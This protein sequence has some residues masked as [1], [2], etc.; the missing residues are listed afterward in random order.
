MSHCHSQAVQIHPSWYCLPEQ[1]HLHVVRIL[2]PLSSGIIILSIHLCSIHAMPDKMCESP[3]PSPPESAE[4]QHELPPKALS[5]K[6]ENNRREYFPMPWCVI[7]GGVQL[8]GATGTLP[9]LFTEKLSSTFL[10]S[11]VLRRGGLRF[12]RR[13]VRG[14]GGA[15]GAQERD[16]L[17]RAIAY[18]CLSVDKLQRGRGR[19]PHAHP[20]ARSE[21]RDVYSDRASH[22]ARRP[23][24]CVF[25]VLIAPLH[26]VHHTFL[27]QLFSAES[28]GGL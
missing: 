24:S 11:R 12:V 17:L 7:S 10:Y 8:N 27:T 26:D 19:Q 14:S 28:P 3:S 6:G 22:P 25:H 20:A 2:F 13:V 15:A 16:T 4:L 1:R 23:S 5:S 9:D 18:R 21:T